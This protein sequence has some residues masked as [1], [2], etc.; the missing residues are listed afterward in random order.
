MNVRTIMI[1]AMIGLLAAA[2]GC[3]SKADSA[4]AGKPAVAVDTVT[5]APG[6]FRESVEVVGT[7]E[8][9]NA[10][11]VKSEYSGVVTEVAVT[12]WVPVHKGQV[13]ARMDAREAKSALLQAK[14]QADRDER[15][16]ER[17][18][19]LKAAGLMTAQG[20]EDARTQ[21]DSSRALLGLA[22]TRIDKTVIRS[23]MDGVVAYRGVSVGD[24]VENMGAPKPMFRIVDNRLFDLEVTVPSG[25]IHTVKVGQSLAFST[26]AVPGKTFEGKVSFINPAAD[27]ASRAVKIVAMVPNASGEL[28]TG[29]FVKGR[30]LT[31]NRA[32]VLQ[33]PKEALL[34]WDVQSNKAEVFVLEGD[35]VHV[36]SIT[37]GA[38]SDA[39][40]EIVTGL[41]AGQEVVTRGAFNLGDG[42]RVVRAPATGA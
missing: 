13:L 30:I 19:N 22:K 3:A 26:D 40:V 18:Q 29:T 10:A 7:L 34:K 5:V 4:E 16:Y 31:Q 12:E 39:T 24:Y 36:R 42:D 17:A 41:S 20:L 14:V 15:E 32:G 6:Y 1:P 8:A 21:R 38:V 27:L 2:G 37:T 11:A 28:R 33:V 25:R 23:P 35:T 9:K